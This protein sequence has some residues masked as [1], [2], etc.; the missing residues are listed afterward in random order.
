MRATATLAFVFSHSPPN[1]SG[2]D[3][4]FS[5]LSLETAVDEPS[6]RQLMALVEQTERFA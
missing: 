6:R 5:L 2:N 3:L 1:S 4:T